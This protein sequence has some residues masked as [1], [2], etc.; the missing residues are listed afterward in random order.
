MARMATALDS[1]RTSQLS[2]FDLLS[3]AG[4]AHTRPQAPDREL[5][6]PAQARLPDRT[7][8]VTRAEHLAFRLSQEL[9]FPVR[10]SVTDNRST[11][12]SFRRGPSALRLRLH[13]MFL[14]APV[15]V[16]Q[17]ISNYAGRGQPRAGR[18]LDDYIRG[19]QP[20]I[21]RERVEGEQDLHPRG[22]HFDLQQ[23]FDSLN[24]RF[25]ANEIR[26]RI[27]WG[28]MPSTRRR[29]SIR[30]GVYDHVTKEIRIHPALDRAQ[31]PAYFVE[32]I[33]YHEML[34]PLFPSS[35]EDGRR[36][37]HPR[38]FRERERA[39]PLFQTAL[40]WEKENLKLLL[41]GA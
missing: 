15:P 21:R 22:S 9:G 13:H 18:V 20:L 17:A 31:V 37:H 34:H 1:S 40:R 29:K 27:G 26:A 4:P 23:M 14:D 11:M 35:G 5:T 25:F 6:D 10:L 41:R 30:L 16:V 28:R 33:V 38:A 3:V 8:V 24:E 36:V 32:F 2:L 12:V 39:F 7:D 19:R